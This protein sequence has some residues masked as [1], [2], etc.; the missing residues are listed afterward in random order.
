MVSAVTAA[1]GELGLPIETFTLAPRFNDPPHYVLLVEDGVAGGRGQALAECIERHMEGYNCEYANRQ[2]TG[3]LGPLE[4]REIPRGTWAA[5]RQRR[6]ARLGGSLEQ[7]KRPCL[8]SDLEFVS[9]VWRW[10]PRRSSW[11]QR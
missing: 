8:T 10:A 7:Y 3:R 4:V 9:T 1:F 11:P 6:I 2:Q 5:Y